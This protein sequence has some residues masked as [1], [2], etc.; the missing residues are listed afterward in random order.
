MEKV[1]NRDTRYYIDLDLRNQKILYWNYG[2]RHLL[3]A[4]KPA[5]HYYHRIYITKGQYKKLEEKY[6]ELL[7][8]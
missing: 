4:E 3:F 7:N 8:K 6:Q 2:D 5:K 1:I